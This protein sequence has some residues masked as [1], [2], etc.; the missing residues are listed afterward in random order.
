MPKQSELQARIQALKSISANYRDLQRLVGITTADPDR[1]T[2]MAIL[3]DNLQRTVPDVSASAASQN[4]NVPAEP[5]RP[6]Y[7]ITGLIYRVY[8]LGRKEQVIDALIERTDELTASLKTVRAPIRDAFRAELSR[9]AWDAISLDLLQ[10][11]Q[12]RMTNLVGQVETASPAMAALLKQQTLLDLYR[13]HLAEWRS[14]TQLENGAAWKAFLIRLMMLAA[15]VATL[16]G[17]N[18][19]ASRLA[20]THVRDADTRQVLLM[21]E[22]FLLWLAIILVVM[23]AFA[24]DLSSLATFLGLLSAG[25]AV[26]LHDVLLAVGGYLL[27][28]RRFRVRVG[29]RVE[30]AGVN[31]EV[32]E[33][34]LMQF[35]VSEVDAKTGERTGRNV[36]FSNSYVFVSPATPL[37]RELGSRPIA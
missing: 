16:L 35:E 2:D 26:G 10:E 34:G 11:Q 30:I 24:L 14:G 32:T 25:L 13:S 18:A 28:V 6:S 15:A 31:G 9:L 23:F 33:L 22:R 27:L 19:L 8:S 12:S 7:G 29:D 21:G 5:S 17:M 37:F 4:A 36:F 1:P 3:L 20:R